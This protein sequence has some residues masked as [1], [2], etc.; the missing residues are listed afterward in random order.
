MSH[1]PCT[2]MPDALFAPLVVGVPQEMATYLELSDPEDAHLNRLILR[3]KFYELAGNPDLALR[4]YDRILSSKG[5]GEVEGGGWFCKGRLLAGS[6]DAGKRRAEILHC[7]QKSLECVIPSSLRS[8]VHTQLA[9]CHM[10]IFDDEVACLDSMKRALQEPEA[11]SFIKGIA[12]QHLAAAAQ[13][14]CD[15]SEAVIMYG[16]AMK[17]Q[18]SQNACASILTNLGRIYH[19]VYGDADV[20]ADYWRQAGPLFC[21]DKI[22][23]DEADVEF[24]RQGLK[25]VK[26]EKPNGA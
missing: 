11:P 3:A 12:F 23:Y 15:Y 20:A 7:F 17:E 13:E 9:M 22:D 24:C 14:K 25:A 1:S 19:D 18:L 10:Y 5:S 26:G 6:E 16:H 21:P 4:V 2:F 8:R